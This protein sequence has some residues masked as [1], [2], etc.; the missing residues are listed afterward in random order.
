MFG[1]GLAD[2]SAPFDLEADYRQR[3]GGCWEESTEESVDQDRCHGG[4][5]RHPVVVQDRWCHG[6]DHTETSRQE[7]NI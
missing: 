4:G 3:A 1:V 5:E 2:S 7:R 6:L